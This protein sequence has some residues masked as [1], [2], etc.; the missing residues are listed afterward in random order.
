MEDLD[1]A[2]LEH[3]Y[4]NNYTYTKDGPTPIR[5]KACRI[6]CTTR[7]RDGGCFSILPPPNTSASPPFL[8]TT[9]T[10]IM[11]TTTVPS[12]DLSRGNSPSWNSV[13]TTMGPPAYQLEH[14][15]LPDQE[16][17]PRPPQLQY[18]QGHGRQR[19][20]ETMGTGDR[21]LGEVNCITCGLSH[22]PTNGSQTHC[23]TS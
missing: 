2:V 4:P 23:S 19:G 12:P 14:F 13:M 9:T 15:Y 22:F 5:H 8:R 1:W 10:C 6:R 21:R 7:L 11:N 3:P 17:H 20:W 16:R 18:M